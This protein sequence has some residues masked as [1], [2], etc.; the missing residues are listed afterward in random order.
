LQPSATATIL[1][2]QTLEDGLHLEL[3]FD[4]GLKQALVMSH[5]VS[6]ILNEALGEAALASDWKR[7]G[8][9]D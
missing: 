6:F 2:P 1:E 4:A 3:A 5:D 7:S 8:W 9:L